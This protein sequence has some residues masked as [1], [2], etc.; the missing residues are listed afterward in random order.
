MWIF[1]E[2]LQAFL[3]T[4]W[5]LF[6]EIR[7]FCKKR[8]QSA[9]FAHR[10]FLGALAALIVSLVIFYF[11][12]NSIFGANILKYFSEMPSDNN[13]ISAMSGAGAAI[14]G[15]ALT[16]AGAIVT[17][18]LAALAYKLSQLPR[19]EYIQEKEEKFVHDYSDA[20]FALMRS[21]IAYKYFKQSEF[22]AW[23]ITPEGEKI[24]LSEESKKASL[25]KVA[26]AYKEL[27]DSILCFADTIENLGKNPLAQMMLRQLMASGSSKLLALENEFKEKLRDQAIFQYPEMPKTFFEW[28][29]K[30]RLRVLE[31]K[32]QDPFVI[33]ESQE[34]ILESL[35]NKAHLDVLEPKGEEPATTQNRN[36]DVVFPASE[37]LVFCPIYALG[38]H[39]SCDEYHV[40][41]Q[42]GR[43]I[44][45]CNAHSGV[46]LLYDFVSMLPKDGD[47]KKII[48]EYFPEHAPH[49]SK[50]NLL[51]NLESA[52]PLDFLRAVRNVKGLVSEDELY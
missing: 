38:Y 36:Y 42:V 3:K 14:I 13:K 29:S 5:T 19:A 46:A 43:I 4:R 11:F 48:K 45:R 31:M 17:I 15:Y 47:W 12:F 50:R 22:Q 24:N 7:S 10:V 35:F 51:L 26:Y 32:E 39:L 23:N 21:F 18:V 16:I 34:K 8:W 9:E 52:F 2:R 27:I 44:Y 49:I 20:I 33:T 6:K 37:P 28:A 25:D 1:L 30:L 40:K 41:D